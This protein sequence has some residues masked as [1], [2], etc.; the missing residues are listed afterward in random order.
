MK[1]LRNIKI[2]STWFSLLTGSLIL[3]TG[4]LILLTGCEND[5]DFN[6][7]F[8]SKSI[9]GEG[10]Y[11]GS[12]WPTKNW[13]SCTP[14]EVGMDSEL[15]KKLNED[16]VLQ[17]RLHIDVHSVL[18][19]RRG[20]IVAEQYYNP[21]FSRD[22][23]HYVYSCTKSILSAAFGIAREKAYISNLDTAILDFFPEYAVENPGTKDQINLYH[24]LTMSD[25]LEWNEMQYLYGDERNTFTQWRNEGGKN[26]FVLNRP[27]NSD[28][29]VSFN[30]NSG[31]SQL[32]ASVIEKQTGTRLDSFVK[33][34][35]FTPLGIKH[36]NWQLNPDGVARGYSGVYLSPRD[37]AKFG[38]LYLEN[39]NWEQSQVLPEEWVRES[40]D[41]HILRRDIPG[42]YYG[43]HWWVHE[44][45]LI[46][47]V[48]FGGQLLMI[49][50]EYDLIVLF[51]NYHN[52][53]DSFQTDTPWRLLD[54][55]IIPAIID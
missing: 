30:Y 7:A 2:Q 26:E 45:G 24:A 55:F 44:N 43:Y 21:E 18:I 10:P 6:P 19:I 34:E 29:G 12:Y 11:Q 36:Y 9:L 42:F 17:M 22:S 50:P 4:G 13:R 27:Q 40:T 31:I 53:E 8:P 32:L 15:L 52:Q 35:L 28:P 3:L 33:E 54:T 20:Y 48:G 23:L 46:A 39:G 25:G 37:L 47:A 1:Q 41:K 5:Q 38:L 16:M 14:E 49:I 51:T